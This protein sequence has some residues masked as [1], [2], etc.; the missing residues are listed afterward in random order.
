MRKIEHSDFIDKLKNTDN[1]DLLYNIVEART[2]NHV[3][4]LKLIPDEVVAEAQRAL[5]ALVRY[6]KF[7]TVNRPSNWIRAH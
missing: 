6:S 3:D 7:I 5:S 4:I 1:L 2:G